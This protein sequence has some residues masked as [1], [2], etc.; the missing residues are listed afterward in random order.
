MF[1][2]RTG[3][4]SHCKSQTLATN[5]KKN[6]IKMTSWWVMVTSK[7][8]LSNFYVKGSKLTEVK[9]FIH[10]LSPQYTMYIWENLKK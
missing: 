5:L 2:V 6:N 10:G 9:P 4:L 7:L 1:I 3:K 8:D